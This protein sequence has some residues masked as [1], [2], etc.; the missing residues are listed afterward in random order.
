VT[1][2][3]VLEAKVSVLVLSWKKSRLHHC[4]DLD[5]ACCVWWLGRL[6]CVCC[7]ILDF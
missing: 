3:V 1:S 5:I 6:S 4:Y 2:D 7:D